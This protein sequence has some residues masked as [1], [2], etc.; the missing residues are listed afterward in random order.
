MGTNFG[1][2]R[3]LECLDGRVDS[4]ETIDASSSRISSVK[5]PAVFQRARHIPYQY[6]PLPPE[7]EGDVSVRLLTIQQAAVDS[8]PLE[9]E[10]NTVH[11]RDPAA[12]H[13]FDAVSYVWGPAEFTEYL[14][15]DD[16]KSCLRNYASAA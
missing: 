5:A 16:A 2:Y 8:D 11:F 1:H 14:F 7:I 9:C 3:K 10:I 13:T 6:E 4:H 12:Y 15:C